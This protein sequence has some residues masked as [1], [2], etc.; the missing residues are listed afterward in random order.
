MT[1]EI[2]VI[3]LPPIEHNGCF[4]NDSTRDYIGDGLYVGFDGFR[5]WVHANDHLKPT[6]I[7]CLEPNILKELIR[8]AKRMG[9]LKQENYDDTN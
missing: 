2:N 1:D 4:S 8:F 7:I 9:V 5:V 6:D 3:M